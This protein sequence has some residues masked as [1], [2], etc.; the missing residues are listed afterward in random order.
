MEAKEE[1]GADIWQ[2]RWRVKY[3]MRCT[4]LLVPYGIQAQSNASIIFVGLQ[5]ETG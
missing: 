2:S 5:K 1:K 4:Q 3:S